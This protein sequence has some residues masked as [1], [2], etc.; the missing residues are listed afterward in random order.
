MNKYILHIAQNYSIEILRPLQAEILA[1]GHECIWYVGGAKVDKSSFKA[2]ETFTSEPS[3]IS[4]YDACAVF[5]P[6]NQV[7]NFLKGLK[8]Q[9]FHGLEW[10]KKGHFRIRDFFDLYCTQGPITTNTFN[11][12]ANQHKNFLVRETG[13]SKLDPLFT[14]SACQVPTNKKVVLYAPT[15]SEK[16][17]SAEACF[18][19]ISR[20]VKEKD[21]HWIVKFHPL[22]KKEWVGMYLSI[23]AD[24]FQVIEEHSILSLL[25]AADVMLSD[26]SSVVGEFLLLGKPVVTLNNSAPGD[27][28]INI[29]SASELERA[30][31]IALKKDPVLISNIQKANEQLHPY[32]DGR[33]SARILDAVDDILTNNIKPAK[34]R[35]WNLLRNFKIRKNLGYWRI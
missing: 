13:W 4:T 1:R 11:Q 35:P 7:P 5:T 30:I 19:E 2:N 33:S 28:L 10:K 32:S 18:D 21:W 9:I 15:F 27:E 22:M 12:L 8:V 3:K 26:T 29:D 23:K 20:L 31:E 16:L 14:T 6:G 17:S 24:N 25:Q 34:K